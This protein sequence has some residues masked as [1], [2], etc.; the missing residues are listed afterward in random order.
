MS[1]LPVDDE[2]FSILPPHFVEV[3]DDVK[4]G[5]VFLLP[6]STGQ[7]KFVAESCLASIVYHLD[8]LKREMRNSRNSIEF[9]IHQVPY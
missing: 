5:I 8:F 9:M 6:N 3:D 7:I 4:Q 1:G 2:L